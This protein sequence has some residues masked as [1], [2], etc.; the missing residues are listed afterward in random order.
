MH[1]LSQV[2]GSD[3]DLGS[4]LRNLT[5]DLGRLRE[6][7]SFGYGK[8]LLPFNNGL[9]VDCRRDISIILISLN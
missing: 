7:P 6:G 4:Q 3:P 9:P 2:Y 1:E 5:N 8:P